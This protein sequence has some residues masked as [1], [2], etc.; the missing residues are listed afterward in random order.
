[1]HFELYQFGLHDQ[2]LLIQLTYSAELHPAAEKRKATVLSRTF[3]EAPYHP[4]LS[5]QMLCVWVPLSF[6]PPWL[7]LRHLLLSGDSFQAP[8]EPTANR[9]LFELGS[10]IFRWELAAF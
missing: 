10:S 8:S 3:S 9:Y 1:M 2:L 4:V 7:L 5:F 6:W